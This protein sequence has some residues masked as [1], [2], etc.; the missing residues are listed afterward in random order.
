MGKV[1]I[2]T[3]FLKKQ[4]WKNG[5][6]FDLLTTMPKDS[7]KSFIQHLHD[8]TT[9]D[10]KFS[11]L[12]CEVE[13]SNFDGVA[14]TFIPKL[15][16]LTNSLQPVY[17][18]S[19]SFKKLV[20]YYQKNKLYQNDMLIRLIKES[21]KL[22][23]LDWVDDS[24]KA[25]L[26]PEEQIIKEVAKERFKVTKGFTF[27]TLC[28]DMGYAGVNIISFDKEYTEKKIDPNLLNHLKHC[29]KLYH[30]HIMTHQDARYQFIL[31]I[32]DSLTPKKKIVLKYLISGQ[33][34]KNITNSEDIT[35]RY[36]EKLLVELRRDFGDISKNELIYFLGLLNISEHL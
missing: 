3:H 21:K 17:Q 16:Q 24:R 32:L 36:A 34:M 31:P 18:Y 19:T 27:P 8:S 28:N 10:E 7:N 15:S 14:Y 23:I 11:V 22:D 1:E 13:S 20:A 30:D 35:T 12:E 5:F 26:S 6:F 25:T 4:H 2:P 29:C 33:P 9:L